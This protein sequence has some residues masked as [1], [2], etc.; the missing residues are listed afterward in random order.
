MKEKYQKIITWEKKPTYDSLYSGLFFILSGGV[1]WILWLSL[2]TILVSVFISW[3][4]Y[5]IVL[6]RRG[7]GHGKKEYYR[8]L[9][10]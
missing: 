4:S 7:K 1:L 3:C 5:G 6:F 8:R 10:K 9:D 2:D